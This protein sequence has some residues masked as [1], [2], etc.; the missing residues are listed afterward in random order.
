ME[1]ES[2]I[3]QSE[4]ALLTAVGYLV[5]RWNYAE[6]FVRQIL[7]QY[8]PGESLRDAA[9]LKLSS[10]GAGLLEE[11][12]RNDALP[13][14]VD[15]GRPFLECLVL[16]YSRAREHRNHLIH[17]I[18]MTMAASEAYPAQAVLLPQKP[19]GGKPQAPSHVQIDE[20]QLVA[21]HCH[22]LAMFA[23]EVSIGF[24]KEGAR[25]LNSDGTPVLAKLPEML[26]PL[27]QCQFVTF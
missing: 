11:S 10:R 27:A 5:L 12:L 23:R 18:F 9:H 25:T 21:R 19:I 20:V 6:H 14:W 17:G 13:S 15:P 22:D 7:R 1:E 2:R 16:A 4:E 8:V 24:S 26:E 3:S